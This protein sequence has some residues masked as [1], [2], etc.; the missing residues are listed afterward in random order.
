MCAKDCSQRRAARD[1]SPE[2]STAREYLRVRNRDDAQAPASAATPTWL[3]RERRG[4]TTPRYTKSPETH[5]RTRR[6]P[7]FDPDDAQTPPQPCVIHDGSGSQKS[8]GGAPP[9]RRQ[10]SQPTPTGP[11]EVVGRLDHC[12][13]RPAPRTRSHQALAMEESRSLHCCEDML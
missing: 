12:R 6:V 13:P 5:A 10:P 4:S 11:W 8:C 2:S 7:S 9:C 1:T 3:C